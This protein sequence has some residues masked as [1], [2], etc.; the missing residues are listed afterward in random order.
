MSSASRKM[1]RSGINGKWYL[2]FCLVAATPCA[3]DGSHGVDTIADEVVGDNKYKDCENI[4]KK[5]DC[6]K[7]DGCRW[8]KDLDLCH[9]DD[10]CQY[11]NN[12]KDCQDVDGCSWNKDLEL[13]HADDDCQYLND[14]KDCQE[15]E[16]CI[17]DKEQDLCRV[18]E[19]KPIHNKKDCQSV[20]GCMWN[21][22]LE[23][24]HADD[25][26]QYFSDKKDCQEVDGCAWNKDLDLCHADDDCQYFHDK[27][28]CQEVDGC[29][30]NKDL[31]LC[32]ADDDED[33]SSLESCTDNASYVDADGYACEDWVG[34]DCHTAV[35]DWGYSEAEVA[36]LLRNCPQSCEL[37]AICTD[38]SGYEDAYGYS[39]ED[40]V[41]YDC[42]AAVEDWE[43]SE[44]QEADL[45]KNCPESCE[46]CGECSD[47]LDYVD[48]DG[49]SCE[50]WVGYDCFGAIEEWGYS[51]AEEAD[52]I[53]NCPESCELCPD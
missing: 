49:Y 7:V 31:D 53:R 8:N 39:C 24:C 11:F 29:A 32:Y 52:L 40:W 36:E 18:D 27:K 44:A 3:C 46:L 1:F 47:T 45:I 41:G 19:C 35:A 6:Q 10:D 12:K 26:C 2:L 48:A 17:W 5:K 21:K 38:T 13:C 43:Y 4:H 14:K 20:D 37:C 15:V 16:D 25:D 22:D 42:Q 23:L 33:I 50:D 30:W 51:A 28:D 9:A 34:Y